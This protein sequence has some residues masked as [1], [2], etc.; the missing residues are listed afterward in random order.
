MK[1]VCRKL[2]EKLMVVKGRTVRKK[3]I[4]MKMR[5]IKWTKVK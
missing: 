4:F 3:M 2:E 5:K 1:M